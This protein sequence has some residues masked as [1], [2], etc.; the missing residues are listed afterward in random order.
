[1]APERIVPTFFRSGTNRSD[2]FPVRNESFRHFIGPE[3][4]VP[5]TERFLRFIVEQLFAINVARTCGTEQVCHS[6]FSS[7]F[8][9]YDVLRTRCK[10]VQV[11]SPW[12]VKPSK[13]SIYHYIEN[14]ISNHG[15]WSPNSWWYPTRWVALGRLPC[16]TT[17]ASRTS[18]QHSTIPVFLRLISA[19]LQ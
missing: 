4:I 11:P 13:S 6:M 12:N 3:R 15:S 7:M 8:Y 14:I 2:V 5:E 18:N 10:I 16:L 1:M 19:C 9:A 17:A